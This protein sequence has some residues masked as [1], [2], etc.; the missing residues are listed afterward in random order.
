[1]KGWIEVTDRD[2]EDKYLI[3]LAHVGSVVSNNDTSTVY[4]A[5]D[6]EYFVKETYDELKAKI[7]EATK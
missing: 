1:M 6:G 7:E 5:R 2:N 4:D 3:N